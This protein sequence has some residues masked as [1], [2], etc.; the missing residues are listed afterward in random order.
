MVEV[1]NCIEQLL[2]FNL[3]IINRIPQFYDLQNSPN[4]V[5]FITEDANQILHGF[6]Q[7]VIDRVW[8]LTILALEG[9]QHLSRGLFD[10]TGI[11]GGV[12]DGLCVLG[13]GQASATAEDKQVRKRIAA[14]PVCAV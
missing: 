7:I 3:Y 14:Q 5:F 12:L 13:G 1:S 6:L 4:H 9:G 10:L 8:T 11:D 2:T